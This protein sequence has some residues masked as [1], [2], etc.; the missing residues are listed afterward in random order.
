M[1]EEIAGR[2]VDG[3]WRDHRVESGEFG[4]PAAAAAARMD[5]ELGRVS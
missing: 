1:C 5:L 4:S 2:M 3:W